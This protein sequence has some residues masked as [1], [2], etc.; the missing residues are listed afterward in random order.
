MDNKQK[1]LK[2]VSI[3]NSHKFFKNRFKHLFQN[4]FKH[5]FQNRFKHLFQNCF[6]HYF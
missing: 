3:L 2:T 6:K 4:R 1:R 5:L